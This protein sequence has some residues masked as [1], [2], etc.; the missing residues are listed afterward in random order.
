[1]III[2]EKYIKLFIFKGLTNVNL[3]VNSFVN[4]VEKIGFLLKK[5]GKM[6]KKCQKN[7]VF[8]K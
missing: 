6:S 3:I 7:D 1:M 5:R 8:V 2:V 4:S